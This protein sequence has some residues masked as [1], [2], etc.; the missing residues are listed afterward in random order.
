MLREFE[1][2]RPQFDQL[3]RSA[4]GILSQ[5]GDSAQE[6]QDLEEVRTE[7]GSITQQWED[8]TGRLTQRA[9]SIDQAQGTSERYQVSTRTLRE[10]NISRT[11][12]SPVLLCVPGPA[13]RALL[14]RLCPGREAGL[15]GLAERPAR[16]AEAPPA[17]DRRD[18]LGAGA[19]ECGALRGR[20]ALPRAERHRGRAL[21]EGGAEETSG[22]CRIAAEESGGASRCVRL[23]FIRDQ[24]L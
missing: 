5:T 17:G 8:L 14:Q 12:G 24:F 13:Q 9:T 23:R 21:P 1:T 15:S 18:P 3:T 19:T 6:S 16:G 20:A 2:R 11:D 7:L 10:V 4:Q 22:R